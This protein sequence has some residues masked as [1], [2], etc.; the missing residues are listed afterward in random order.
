M[1]ILEKLLYIPALLFTMHAAAQENQKY[2]Q[3][4]AVVVNN[5][6]LAE[7]KILGQ[8]FYAHQLFIVG[9]IHGIQ[10]GQDID[11]TLLT[12][13]N[14][15]LNVRTY[16]AEVDFAKAYLLNQY[17]KTGDEGLIDSVFRDWTEQNVQWANTD[18]K[19]KIRKIRRYNKTVKPTL[20]I[21]FEGIDQIQNPQLVAGYLKDKLN[22]KRA[23]LKEAKVLLAALYDKNDS[24]IVQE[25]T[26]LIKQWDKR[27]ALSATKNQDADIRF[28]LINCMQ[29]SS[30]REAQM[31]KNFKSLYQSRNWSAEK[32]YG[33][34]GFAH[35]LAAKANGGRSTSFVYMLSQDPELNLQ[36]KIA[37]IGLLYVDSK[38]TTP[39]DA[40]PVAWRQ[41]GTRFTAIGQYNHDGPLIRL[42]DI[43]SFKSATK[44]GSV[45]LFDLASAGSPYLTRS[46][47][48]KYA[49]I[50]P[51]SQRLLLNAPGTSITDYLHYVILVRNSAATNPIRE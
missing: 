44:Q 12:F 41:K 36:D 18:F 35:V 43:E 16:V 45:T 47:E 49:D 37:S 24:V 30:P 33:F 46:L 8:E 42:E 34:F 9:E 19:D 38:M 32:L 11:Y 14:R 5:D 7:S 39:N 6:S 40:L 2:L 48:I 22:G 10:K 27:N 51:V 4:H 31:Y 50:M 21:H 29:I 13:L 1:N 25:S 28:A 20:T 3:S 26:A 17:L 15:K 23:L